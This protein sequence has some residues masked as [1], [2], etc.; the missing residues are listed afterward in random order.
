MARVVATSETVSVRSRRL[1]PPSGRSIALQVLGAR[2]FLLVA[3][4]VAQIPHGPRLDPR[5]ASGAMDLSPV[6]F[7]RPPSAQLLVAVPVTAGRR[8]LFSS[9]FATIQ[10]VGREKL[11]GRV[12]N[13]LVRALTRP[14]PSDTDAVH[15]ADCLPCRRSDGGGHRTHR[16][17][18]A[19]APSTMARTVPRRVTRLR[20]RAHVPS[21][22]ED[23][24]TQSPSGKW[25]DPVDPMSYSSLSRSSSTT[26]AKPSVTSTASGASRWSR[27]VIPAAVSE[28]R[29][30]SI[31]QN[32]RMSGSQ[33]RVVSYT[34]DSGVERDQVLLGHRC[35]HDDD[36]GQTNDRVRDAVHHSV[37]FAISMTT[38]SWS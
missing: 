27:R 6:D 13:I 33:P 12:M 37:S 36:F 9:H 5:S 17:C 30:D 14:H 32:P 15:T 35:Q 22:A 34:G 10:S 1:A 3:V 18:M 8:T 29:S 26:H 25:R 24:H 4:H 28:S 16:R 38:S 20:R 7:G 31:L 21:P 23:I 2:V 11:T 19:R